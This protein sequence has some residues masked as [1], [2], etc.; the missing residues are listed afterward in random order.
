MN[1]SLTSPNEQSDADVIQV[2]RA[3]VST[4]LVQK[5]GKEIVSSTCKEEVTHAANNISPVLRTSFQPR[6]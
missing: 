2:E 3:T 4:T 5:K 6:K 1:Q